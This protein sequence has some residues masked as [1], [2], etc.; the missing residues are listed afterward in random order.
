MRRTQILSRMPAR[1]ALASC[2]AVGLFAGLLAAV[3][4]ASPAAAG[5]SVELPELPSV[6]VVPD[7]MDPRPADPAS[8]QALHGDQPAGTE[9]S[10]GAG[11]PTATPLSPSATWSVSPHTGDFTWSYP[12]RVP[13]VP[14]GLVPDLALNYQS[15]AVDGRTS[16]T[17]NQ[18]SWTGD[19]WDLNPGFVERTYGAC[20]ADET[21][22]HH[23][24]ADLCWRSDNA[25]AAFGAGGGMLIRDDATGTWRQK[26][27]DG[28][29]IQR[30]TGAGNGDD[31]GEYWKITTVDGTQYFFGSR[32]AAGST[33]TV[34]VFGDDA[35]EPC[36][37][38]TFAASRCAQA[39]RWN[40]DKIVDRNGNAIEFTYR[41]ETN[42]YGANQR[43]AAVPYVRGGHL[44]RIDYG[45]HTEVAGAPAARVEFAVEDRCVP[46]STCTFDRPENWPDTPVDARCVA[47]VCADHHAPTFWTTKRLASVTTRVRQDGTWTDVDRWTLGHLYPDPGDGE[48]AALWLKSI[49]HTGLVGGQEE[50]EPVT[51][52]G[53]PMPNRVFQEDHLSPLSRYRVTGVVSES[54]GTI[55]VQY[56]EPDCVPGQSM[57][58]HAHTNHLRCFPVTWSRPGHA[59][60]TDW[61]HKYVVRTVTVGDRIS[62]SIDQQTSY[63][64]LDGAA[65]HYDTSEFTPQDKRTWSEFRGFQ[66]VRIRTGSDDDTSGPVTLSE[67]RFYR[68]MHGD[69]LPGGGTRSVVVTDSEGGEHPDHDWLRG[70]PRESITYLGQTATVVEKS[71]TDPVWQG[72]TATRGSFHAYLVRPGTTR[73]FTTL[74]GGGRREAQTTTGYDDWGL[75]ERVDDLGDVGTAADDLC[76]RT[77]YL[78]D[79][80]AWIA[81]PSREQIVSVRCGVAATFPGDAVSDRR[82]SYDDRHNPTRVEVLDRHPASGPE[83]VVASIRDYDRH[84]RPVS[85]TDALDRTTSTTYTPATGGP[86]VRTVVTDPMGHT[87][88]TDWDVAT[89]Q[90]LTVTDANGYVTETAY[91]PLGRVREVWLANRPRAEGFAASYQFDYLVRREAPTVVTTTRIG[92]NGTYLSSNELYDGWLRLRQVQ[93]PAAGGGR[94][95]TDTTYDSHGRVHDR[96][97]GYF[98]SSPVDTDLWRV[99][100]VEKLPGHT[101]TR[102][103]GAGRPVAT[104]FKSGA[105]TRWQTTTSYGGDRI[106]LTPVQGGIPTTTVY[107]ARGRATALHQ[108]HGTTPRGARDTTTYTYTPAGQLAT[109]TDPA[110]NTWRYRYDLR[111][112]LVWTDDPDKGEATYR[113]DPAGQLTSLTDAR[114]QVLAYAYDDLGRPL[115]IRSGGA[116]GPMLASWTYDTVWRGKGQP[117]TASTYDRDGNAYTTAVHAYSARYEPLVTSVTVP[118][119]EGLLAGRYLSRYGYNPDGSLRS[120]VYPRAGDLP[121]EEVSYEYDDAG[122]PLRSHG[123][124]EGSGETV[125]YAARTDYTRY[126]EVQRLHLGTGTRRAWQSLYYD[127]ATRRVDRII[128]D[129]EVPRPMQA[130]RHYTYD[131]AGNVL[132]LADTAPGRP[133]DIQCYRYDYLRRLIE[134]W[135]AAD[136]CATDPDAGGLAGPAPYW[137]SFRYDLV[138]NRLEKVDH[139]AGGR[140]TSYTYPGSGEPRPHALTSVSDGVESET[141][142][143]DPA[144]NVIVRD[145]QHL[146]WDALGHLASVTDGDTTTE[147]RYDATG[148]RLIRRDPT[149]ATLYLGKQEVRADPAAGTLTGTRYYTHAG[150][151]VAVRT[152]SGVDWLFSDHHGTAEVTVDAATLQTAA[153]RLD[154][155]GLPRGDDPAGWPDERGFVGGTTDP[156]TG[157]TH[158]GAREYDPRHGRFI[159]VDPLI[160][161][162]DPQQMNGYAYA[163]NSPVTMTDPDGLFYYISLNGPETAPGAG[164]Q[165]PPAPPS[166]APRNGSGCPPDRDCRPPRQKV[167]DEVLSQPALGYRPRVED[168][169]DLRTFHNYQ[170]SDA[171]TWRDALEFA[172]QSPDGYAQVCAALGIQHECGMRAPGDPNPVLDFVGEVTGISD[173]VDCFGSGDAM[174]CLDVAVSFNPVGKTRKVIAAATS[175]SGGTGRS[176]CGQPNSFVAGTAVLMADG[177][178]MPIERVR[179]GDLVLATDPDTGVTEA[180]PVTDTVT[181]TGEKELVRISLAA[182][183][184]APTAGPVIATS[185]LWTV[186]ATGHHPFRLAGQESWTAAADLR[187]GHLLA[188]AGGSVTEVGPVAIYTAT[189]TVHNL[190]VADLH[191]YYV[192]VGGTAVLVHNCPGEAII[193]WD[194]GHANITVTTSDGKSLTTDLVVFAP[195][196]QVPAGFPT[197]GREAPRMALVVTSRR[198]DLPDADAARRAQQ[199]SINAELGPY[200]RDNNCLTYCVGILIAGGVDAPAGFRGIRWLESQ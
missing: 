158:L 58:V 35:G 92:P 60:R 50:L 55:D 116:A 156:T 136:D 113:H 142:Q 11:T 73:T 23:D 1:R 133:A 178:T 138:G 36:H 82:Y 69:R 188:G 198:F 182:G 46:G 151:T 85:V 83:Y 181:G 139:A 164:A 33:W 77:T 167:L 168:V 28:A 143:Y 32:P 162:G 67:Q 161:P 132:S 63:E 196:G 48:K 79:G 97:G 13:P 3:A 10:D 94:L 103:D 180:R 68:G 59:E 51:F 93:A 2:L 72:P 165:H 122:R 110:G 95:L 123:G 187:P 80:T 106:H 16:A 173:L 145:D 4:P 17:N 39:W 190:T 52:E 27:D 53:A 195:P 200:G 199:D 44:W 100:D 186:T 194:G 65:W 5:P 118:E 185:P 159:S 8:R 172:A 84:G 81:S 105:S 91:D 90:P 179:P 64:Y 21:G 18:P 104:V 47:D 54:G 74:A 129:A 62:S 140:T 75:P 127:E 157:L 15:S 135:T 183:E 98:N 148:Q 176:G 66:R 137:Q 147:F 20:A 19:G 124:P 34:P 108:Y 126:G 149:G 89:G 192:V 40:L 109:V 144:G 191:T 56:A 99:S 128:V 78:R 117:A 57:P 153:R 166:S 70:F 102:Y 197:M 119:S 193:D 88:A 189:A 130:D 86:L 150:A 31:N 14:G 9:P 154:P 61:F 45:L 41:T 141:Y 115:S 43:D 96:T 175:A 111:G 30:L 24:T 112:D 37:G 125:W 22:A 26:A 107:D 131:P 6:P 146:D 87:R 184:T 121:V 174:A 29:R 170:G 160:D 7:A 114:G 169:R 171:F 49:T 101:E 155:F 134:A 152:G 12:L 120:E 42:S 71:L 76:T 177:T 38:S 163:N 25:T